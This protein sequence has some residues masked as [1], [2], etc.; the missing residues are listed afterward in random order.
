[1]PIREFACNTEGCPEHG[2]VREGYFRNSDSD[3]NCKQCG[4]VQQVQISRFG[5]VWTGPLTRYDNKK[6]E[7]SGFEGSWQYARNTPDGKVRAE[8]IDTPAKSRD[9]AKREGLISPF[10][11]NAPGNVE[12]SDDGRTATAAGLPGQW[13]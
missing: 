12:T 3:P 9:F 7:R 5:I 10:S 1:M 11:P 4:T 6:L 2:V 8:Y 13:I